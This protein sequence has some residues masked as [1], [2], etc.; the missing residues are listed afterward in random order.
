MPRGD[1]DLPIPSGQQPEGSRRGAVLALIVI[2]ALV[3]GGLFLWREI[4]H[5]AA[6][7]DCVAQGRTNCAPVAAPQRQ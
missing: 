1:E 3:A 2:V 6:I 5:M 7:Q 4:S